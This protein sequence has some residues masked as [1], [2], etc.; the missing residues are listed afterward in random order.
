MLTEIGRYGLAHIIQCDRHR[1]WDENLPYFVITEGGNYDIRLSGV[2]RGYWQ[3]RRWFHGNFMNINGY[4]RIKNCRWQGEWYAPEELFESYDNNTFNECEY[5]LYCDPKGNEGFCLDACEVLTQ[6]IIDKMD[7]RFI[8]LAKATPFPEWC[9]FIKDKDGQPML[10]PEAKTFE[11]H[12]ARAVVSTERWSK[13][14]KSP[15]RC[16]ESVNAVINL[17]KTVEDRDEFYPRLRKITEH[18]W[19]KSLAVNGSREGS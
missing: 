17:C 8:Q 4:G 16:K 11:E 1:R 18:F 3:P 13:L 7:A 5:E 9:T 2:R 14:T 15:I 6:D 10:E 12:I 19:M